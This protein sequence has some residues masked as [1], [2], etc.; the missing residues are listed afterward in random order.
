MIEYY[1]KIVMKFD[2]EKFLRNHQPA[3]IDTFKINMYILIINGIQ[4]RYFLEKL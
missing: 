3:K 4:F 2:L 1:I